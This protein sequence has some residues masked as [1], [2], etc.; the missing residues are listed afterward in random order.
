LSEIQQAHFCPFYYDFAP[1]RAQIIAISVS[2]CLSVHSHTSKTTRPNFTN[3]SVHV[4]CG[5]GSV[6]LWRQCSMLCV[7]PVL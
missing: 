1:G 4:T 7:L 6:L 2:V 3:F 5:H